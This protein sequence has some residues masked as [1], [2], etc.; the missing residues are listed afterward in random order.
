MTNLVIDG[1]NGLIISPTVDDLKKAVMEM[2]DKPKI[3]KKFSENGLLVAREAFT[4]DNWDSRWE[5]EIQRVR[6]SLYGP[7]S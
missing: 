7:Y 3:R 5:D 4:K 6:K 2:I 1:F